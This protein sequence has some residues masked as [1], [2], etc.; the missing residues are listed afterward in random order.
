M[1]GDEQPPQ[2]HTLFVK[3]SCHYCTLLLQEM[4]AAG[5]SNEF[6]VVDVD[7]QPVDPRVTHVPALIAD[8]QHMMSGRDAVAWVVDFISKTPQCIQYGQGGQWESMSGCFSFIDEA[9]DDSK[10]TNS[11]MS[12]VFTAIDGAGAATVHAATPDDGGR[13]GERDGLSDAMTRLQEARDASFRP[14]QRS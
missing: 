2:P 14:P 7:E 3:K 11:G 1:P 12:T 4:D 9:S 6:H 8:H 13:G 10:S 5:V